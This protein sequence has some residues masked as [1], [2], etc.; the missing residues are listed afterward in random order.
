MPSVLCYG[1]E[2]KPASHCSFLILWR[3]L[4]QGAGW[5]ILKPT[6]KNLLWSW[7]ECISFC[8]G[9][10]SQS[11]A[12]AACL[13]LSSSVCL[14]ELI[15]HNFQGLAIWTGFYCV[16]I[17]KNPSTEFYGASQVLQVKEA[18]VGE[19]AAV[20]SGKQNRKGAEPPACAAAGWQSLE[21]GWELFWRWNGCALV[22]GGTQSPCCGWGCL[23]ELFPCWAWFTTK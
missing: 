10:L 22:A 1:A 16:F 21:R 3:W 15:Y 8:Y 7:N 2:K 12:S 17:R 23:A 13:V 14:V 11:A 5:R 18:G 20:A 19:P 6:E 4:F 9:M